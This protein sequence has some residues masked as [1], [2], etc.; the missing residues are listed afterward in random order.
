MFSWIGGLVTRRARTV[1]VLGL[2]A[3]VVAAV[4][5]V[6]AFGKL[7]AAGFDDPASES[8][9][10]AA[11]LEDRFA[12]G[13]DYVFVVEA[14]DG[15]VDS[16]ASAGAGAALTER[17]RADPDLADVVSYFDTRAGP[18][19]STDGRYALVTASVAAGEEADPG[20]VLDEYAGVDGPLTVD[21]GG[22]EVVGEEIGAQIGKD[23][24]LAESIAIPLILVLLVLAFGNVVGALV[25]LGVGVAAIFGT[26]AELSILG[27][28]TDVS[29]YAVNLTTGLGLGLAVDYGLL[30]V[31]RVREERAA[32]RAHQD[33]VRRAVET[34]GRTIAFSATTVAVALAALLVFPM[35]FLRSFAYAGIG[36]MLITAFAAVVVLP[37]GLS[38]LGDRVDAW[39]VPRVRGIR[40]EE[41]PAWA[42][43]ARFVARR[44]LLSALPVL[45]GL[46]VVAIPLAGI[47]LGTPDDRV[48]PTSASSRQ[49]GDALRSAFGG[50]G[51]HPIQVVTTS[52]VSEADLASYAARLGELP[53]VVRVDTRAGR[54]ADL[55]SVVSDLDPM[56][57]DARG[58]VDDVRAVSAPGGTDALVGGASAELHDQ[59]TGIGDRL[60]LVAGW[61][62]LTTLVILFLFTGSVV[63][64]LRALVLNAVG[65]G[66]TLGAMV[67]VFQD[68]HLSGLLGFTPQPM[69]SSMMVLLFCVAFGLS[70]DYE[71]FVMSRIK[72]MRD[73]G[74]SNDEA[75]VHGLAHT[76]RIVSTAA[77]LIAISFFAF[78]VS[79]VSF[80]QFF[81]LGTGLAIL[82]DA[83]L[84]RGVLL[85]ASIRL[86]GERSWWAPRPLRALHRRIGLSETV[87][88]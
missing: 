16:T 31:A 80:I 1:L 43:L 84:I 78:L 50:D 25:T 38:L 40:G 52:T 67:W 56:S 83:T 23:L 46:L 65:L 21:V 4:V 74:M 76:G 8:S 54:D 17:L 10:A 53:G 18:M 33:A 60:P 64:P 34:A 5:G 68:G 85:P 2:L 45:A 88:A 58:L 36:V 63:Q 39:R 72:E 30:M 11:L 77:A 26:F 32:G 7:Q 61:L 66:A 27:S 73:R 59:M 42:R 3:V 62:V 82:I 75:L 49:A 14:A 55:V 9:R 87:P 70:M 81:G 79:S 6:G 47:E 12:G 29:I 41:A 15:D 44:P 24:G 37:A 86:L 19:R 35:Y 51:T 20:A 71:V 13:A 57:A 48:L 69:D 22:G 28:A